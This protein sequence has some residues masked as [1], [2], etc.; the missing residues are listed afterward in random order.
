ME[1]VTF[2]FKIHNHNLYTADVGILS[3]NEF[4]YPAGGNLENVITIS[5][6]TQPVGIAI[7]P[8]QMP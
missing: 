4:A 7:T 6:A 8:A 5:G 2:A 3:A 1:P